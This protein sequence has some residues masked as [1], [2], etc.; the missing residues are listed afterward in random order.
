MAPSWGQTTR[1]GDKVYFHVYNWP[2]ADT[3][4]HIAKHSD[5]A[6]F[7]LTNPR[8]LGSAQ[9]VALTPSG[10]G[11]DITPSGGRTNPY[12][13]VIEAT[14]STAPAAV[15]AGTGLKA[16][17]WNNT[18]AT[19][20]PAVTRTDSDINYAW[21][22]SGSPAPTIQ[23][24]N[25][26]ARWTGDIQPRYSERYTFST[27]SNGSVK[28]TI[29]GQQVINAPHHSTTRTDTGSISLQAGQRY[30]IQ[31]DYTALT[32][33]A[34][35]QLVW[36][37][38]NQRAQVVPAQHL[39]PDSSPQINVALGRPATQSSAPQNAAKAVD[40]NTN[41]V[42]AAGSV[43]HTGLDAHAWWQVDLG[44]ST[45]I[46]TIKINSRTDGYADRSSN[47]SVFVSASDM[48]GRSY[49]D[50]RADPAVWRYD[51]AGTPPPELTLPVAAQGRYVRVQ[52]P[53]TNYL[54]LAEVSVYTSAN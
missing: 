18:T 2:A 33:E 45:P 7:T 4:L 41:G 22:Y 43:T 36:S 11:Y 9:S 39:Y 31:V 37:S 32:G 3:A 34:Y 53:G 14:I 12:S 25:F 46:N 54:S 19:G 5:A 16:Q 26:S 40:G 50:L 1:K 8:V 30:N 47:A 44:A 10:D 6:P 51:I 28:V 15:G 23:T 35:A 17:F 52:L 21:R 29:N 48:T 20:A 49:A 27:V 42:Y 13:T 38:P 24:D